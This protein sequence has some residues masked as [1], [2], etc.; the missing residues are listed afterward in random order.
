MV[1]S[2]EGGPE[3]WTL[4]ACPLVGDVGTW[5][6]SRLAGL[7]GPQWPGAENH[8]PRLPAA[9]LDGISVLQSDAF[10]QDLDPE[11]CNLEREV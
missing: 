3:S 9:V 10:T 1:H 6:R 2:T 5:L 8:D 7:P 4:L 11:L